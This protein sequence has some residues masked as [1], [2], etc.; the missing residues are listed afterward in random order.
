MTFSKT[1]ISVCKS[2]FWNFREFSLNIASILSKIS[3]SEW[4]QF[5][6]NFLTKFRLKS[7][8]QF[9]HKFRE[10]L[11]LDKKYS[12]IFQTWDFSW[13]RFKAGFFLLNSKIWFFRSLSLNLHL[14][15]PTW[16]PHII[17]NIY[18][19]CWQTTTYIISAH[20]YPEYLFFSS[21]KTRSKSPLLK[22]TRLML[23]LVNT[24]GDL[25]LFFRSRK[26]KI[27]APFW[28]QSVYFGHF[29]S[30]A[31]AAIQK[32]LMIQGWDSALKIAFPFVK[33]FNSSM[34]SWSYL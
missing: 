1:T 23:V 2:K 29:V 13:K 26:F 34:V 31:F 12:Y 10:N 14:D 9:Q 22:P 18:I 27:Q 8:D 17:W 32:I 21:E 11:I 7:S 28:C 25:K 6:E 33:L 3:I 30:F 5:Y 20:Y 4:R 24:I 19:T 16:Y 15:V